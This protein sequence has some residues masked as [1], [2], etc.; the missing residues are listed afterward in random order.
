VAAT[1]LPLTS[2]FQQSN[3][4]YD[5]GQ[6]LAGI[7]AS[8]RPVVVLVNQES[9]WPVVLYYSGHAGWNLPRA[10]SASDIAALP[11]PPP[12]EL[13][14]VLAGDGPTTLPAGWTE[15]GRTDGY[16]LGRKGSSQE[17]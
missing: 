13:V 15:A 6:A 7:A 11:G 5:A 9:Y 1:I 4:Y 8:G 17:C 14:M 3:F 2:L 12:C 16:V 10:S